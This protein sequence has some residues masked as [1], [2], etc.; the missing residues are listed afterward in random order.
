M[1]E[2]STPPAGYSVAFDVEP[3]LAERNRLTV[4][5]RLILAIPHILLVGSPGGAGFAA[6]LGTGGPASLSGNGVLGTAAFVMAIVSWFAIV[7]TGNH[8]RGLW[9]FAKFYMRWRT[10]AIVYT[11]LLRDEYPPFGEND[12]PVTYDVS[13]PELAR[14]RWSVGLRLIYV[15]PHAIIVFFLGIAW[16]VTAVIAWF[17][18][19]FT[20][21]YPEGLYR[22]AVGVMRWSVRVESYVL[23]MRDEYPPFSLEPA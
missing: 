8:P 10:K 19:L 20:G 5:F 18:I 21:K 7:F 16:L 13:Y 3:Q 17:A 14:D 2:A 12:Y 6:G 4:G 11:A 15:I 23:L 9:E 22:F 1:T